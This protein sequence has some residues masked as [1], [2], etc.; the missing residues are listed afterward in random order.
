MLRAI[1]TAS[2]FAAIIGTG[3]AQGEPP[4]DGT[5]PSDA[6]IEASY[7]AF[8]AESLAKIAPDRGAVSLKGAPVT[9]VVGEG[10]DFYDAGESRVILEDLW[11]NPPDETVLGMIFGGGESPNEADWGAAF[12]Y[13]E[14]GYVS[15]A[16][17]A[18]TDYDALLSQM[19]AATRESNAARTAEGYGTVDLV[20]WAVSPVYDASNHRLIWAKDLLFSTSG[21]DHTLNYDMRLLGREGVLSV[22]F[23][24]G[25][26]HLEAIR[27]AGPDVLAMAAFDAGQTY[28]DYR[29]GDKLAG[30]GV[31]GLIAG[32]AGVAVLKKTGLLA[33]LLIFLKKA[34]VL[35][36]IAVI[37]A[38][39]FISGRG[40]GSA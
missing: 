8:V 32:G 24:G 27:T 38:W 34:W 35:I 22:N 40:K 9:L 29:S 20:G 28:A 12:T 30:Y 1:L 3:H 21:G 5:A 23:I 6:E 16:D 2:A 39:R 15:D 26:E 11:G 10:Y 25:I 33:I 37:A 36:P 7:E 19:Q 31:A 4:E 14:T 13:E 18:S 17:A